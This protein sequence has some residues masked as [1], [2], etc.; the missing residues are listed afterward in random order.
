LRLAEVIKLQEMGLRV[1]M[2]GDGVNDAPALAQSDVGIAM[3]AGTDVAK[4]TGHVVLMKDDLLDVVA[5]IQVARYTM[6][7][8]R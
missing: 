7:K 2:V 5:S 4:E 3:G 6:R 8:V 1:A